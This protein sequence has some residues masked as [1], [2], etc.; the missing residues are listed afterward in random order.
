[1]NTII[2]KKIFKD[3]QIF[4]QFV[5]LVKHF[6][7]HRNLV[8]IFIIFINHQNDDSLMKKYNKIIEIFFDY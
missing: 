5:F 3:E 1:M 8:A 7:N 4:F 2:I 6:S